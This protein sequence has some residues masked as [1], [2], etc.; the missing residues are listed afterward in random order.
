MH[1]YNFPPETALSTATTAPA[2]AATKETTTTE[3]DVGDGR[4]RVGWQWRRKHILTDVSCDMYHF[5]VTPDDKYFVYPDRFG[6]INV[7]CMETGRFLLVFKAAASLI[8]DMA[9]SPDGRFIATA[10]SRNE[11]LSVRVFRLDT[12]KRVMISRRNTGVTALAF[13]NDSKYIVF[14]ESS[15][16][17]VVWS[18]E[19]RKLVRRLLY[20]RSPNFNEKTYLYIDSVAVSADDRYVAAGRSNGTVF[21][22]S[23]AT[24][25]RVRRFRCGRA[26]VSFLRFVP[27]APSSLLSFDNTGRIQ[28]WSVET[29]ERFYSHDTG[30]D[31]NIFSV[32]VTPDG[33]QF[34]TA[35]WM[36][37]ATYSVYSTETGRADHT[38]R[39]LSGSYPGKLNAMITPDC[40]F[41]SY[42]INGTTYLYERE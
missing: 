6:Y 30:Y 8:R 28:R 25:E 33:S 36:S 35:H 5:W 26:S 21:V 38:T 34:L 4:G 15:G 29:G 17:L 40:R 7:R 11:D 14:G 16:M 23:L 2:E 18:L 24:G 22:F 41:M 3:I 9:I 31:S 12:G 20:N 1:L 39:T 27:G 37:S 10:S 42:R 13:T 19:R 32:S